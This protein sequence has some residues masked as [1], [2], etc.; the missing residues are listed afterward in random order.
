MR[1]TNEDGVGICKG[2]EHQASATW[3]DAENVDNQKSYDIRQSKA[4]RCNKH[5]GTKLEQLVE[6]TSW[7]SWLRDKFLSTAT[8]MEAG[9][10]TFMM[11][12]DA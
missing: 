5:R 6:G 12:L 1:H 2:I 3:L 4:N 7:S 11:S 8:K 10:T 9:S